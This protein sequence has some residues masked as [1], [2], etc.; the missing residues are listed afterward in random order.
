MIYYKLIGFNA[1]AKLGG[2]LTRRLNPPTETVKNKPP[3]N[4]RSCRAFFSKWGGEQSISV[5]G[6]TSLPE[7]ILVRK[8]RDGRIGIA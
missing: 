3:K 4:I 7:S 8:V 5:L 1:T 6:E 2:P